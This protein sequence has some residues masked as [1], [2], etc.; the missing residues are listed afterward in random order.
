MKDFDD[1]LDDTSAGSDTES[2]TSDLVSADLGLTEMPV[3]NASAKSLRSARERLEQLRENRSLNRFIYDELYQ[4]E[5]A[6]D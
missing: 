6:M 4:P 5:Q 2:S 3:D 1:D